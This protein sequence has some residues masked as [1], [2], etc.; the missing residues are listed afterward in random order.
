MNSF[1]NNNNNNDG[2]RGTLESSF[3]NDNASCAFNIGVNSKR[4]NHSRFHFDIRRKGTPESSRSIA[5]TVESQEVDTTQKDSI[6]SSTTTFNSSSRRFKSPFS[7]LLSPGKTRKF[8]RNNN[9][10]SSSKRMK[11]EKLKSS[12]DG[13]TKT[14]LSSILLE[15]NAP[16]HLHK[17]C[18]NATS[19]DELDK[20]YNFYD[21]NDAIE[22]TSV[23]DTK[24]QNP[25]HVLSGNKMLSWS[26]MNQS[27]TFVNYQFNNHN[28]SLLER[29]T[30]FL[31][32]FMLPSNHEMAIELD[33]DT[34][35][36]FE[37][38]IHDWIDAVYSEEDETITK[39]DHN[40]SKG[41][42]LTNQSRRSRNLAQGANISTSSQIQFKGESMDSS[43]ALGKLSRQ[44]TIDSGF[45]EEAN[46]ESKT[47]DSTF[48]L[49]AYNSSSGSFSD[50]IR[51]TVSNET[52][53]SSKR[54]GKDKQFPFKVR[55][56]AHAEMS[57][58]ML[59]A[60]LDYFE[61]K[62]RDER[63]VMMNNISQ[64]EGLYRQLSRST[65]NS[66]HDAAQDADGSTVNGDNH[67]EYTESEMINASIV[68][69]IA[70]IPHLMKTLLLLKKEEKDRIFKYSVVQKAMMHKD[71]IGVWL[72]IMLQHQRRDITSHALSYLNMLSDVAETERGREDVVKSRQTMSYYTTQKDII[73]AVSSLDGL[74]PSMLTLNEKVVEDVATT[75][76]ISRVLDKMITRS[77]A[78]SIV[79]C[80]SVFLAMLILSFRTCVVNFV[81]ASDMENTLRWIYIGNAVIFYFIIREIGKA[82]SLST[83][84][85]N[86]GFWKKCFWTFWNIIDIFSIAMAVVSNFIMRLNL[87]GSRDTLDGRWVRTC[88]AIT[89]GLL[90]LKVLGLLK[91]I[92]MQLATFVLAI[93]Q[94]SN[95]Q[96]VSNEHLMAFCTKSRLLF[97]VN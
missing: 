19:V 89:T 74:I 66:L 31:T 84:L 37:R 65:K 3:E 85:T 35:I 63:Q 28:S 92:N 54:L 62:A 79:F 56:S 40:T 88:V 5:N 93:V 55:M 60:I 53:K 82:V 61:E 70:S 18:H 15:Y 52:G 22:D 21:F 6:S 44:S 26:T 78:V 86:Q 58:I 57:L 41:S 51:L 38:A 95:V 73:E 71:S 13:S 39:H 4:R 64:T 8:W 25:L 43:R 47:S 91:T 12:H 83:M 32:N 67:L 45:S 97:F 90:W 33:T 20:I 94:V 29:L 68:R 17:A 72:T 96:Q 9:I 27:N 80:D 69:T 75:R 23:K 24:N 49:D 42:M 16:T 59:S 48:G 46:H 30:N 1:K 81:N 14:S 10:D 34:Y 7:S 76:I 11:S 2:E 36:P 77:F 87:D 50:K